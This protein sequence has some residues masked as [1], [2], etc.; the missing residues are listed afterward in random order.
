LISIGRLDPEKTVVDIIGDGSEY[1]KKLM[2][3]KSMLLAT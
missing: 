1:I 3:K 2:E